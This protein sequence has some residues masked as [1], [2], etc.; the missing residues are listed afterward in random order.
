MTSRAIHLYDTVLRHRTLL[1]PG[2]FD[3]GVVPTSGCPPPSQD[4]LLSGAGLSAQPLKR[5][6]AALI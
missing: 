2:Q 1:F 4:A 3:A 5:G 6:N